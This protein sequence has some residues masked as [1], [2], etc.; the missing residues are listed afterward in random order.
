MQLLTAQM[1]LL[2]KIR[3]VYLDAFTGYL[4]KL[5]EGTD[6][7]VEA[8]L[9]NAQGLLVREGLLQAGM[10]LDLVLFENG[11]AVRNARV[12]SAHFAA[13]DP[14]LTSHDG[15]EIAMAPFTW[16]MVRI[17]AATKVA[18][19]DWLPLRKWYESHFRETPETG[20]AFGECIHFLS[21][22]EPVDGGFEIET[23][24][25]SARPA[26]L[27]ALIEALSACG[28]SRLSLGGAT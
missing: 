9:V 23:D 11:Q 1:D 3:R 16:D 22:P 5:P 8:E 17:T 2:D 14:F 4:D 19:P 25:G 10:R 18:P 27:L 12:G 15:I 26:A 21:D 28:M 6:F 20:T 7:A 24:L 13:F